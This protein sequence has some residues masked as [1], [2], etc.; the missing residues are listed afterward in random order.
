[1]KNLTR[2]LATIVAITFGMSYHAYA[3]SYTSAGAGPADWNTASSWTPAGI[4]TASDNVTISTGHTITIGAAGTCLGLTVNGTLNFTAN[5]VLSIHGNYIVNAGGTE[6]GTVGNL[7]FYTP[8]T[9][10]TTLGTISNA[11]RYYFYSSRTIAAGSVLTK[12]T[13][14]IIT[15][16]SLVITNKGN[17]TVS[18]I[19]AHSTST[20]VN[21]SGA[22]LTVKLNGFMSAGK[23]NASA[24]P[25]TVV[26]AYG[27]GTFSVPKTQLAS[28][29]YNLTI[30]TSTGT[31]SMSEDLIVAGNLTIGSSMTFNTNNFNLTVKG[32]W[33]NG[34][35]FV[36]SAGKTITL[37]GTTA[38]SVSNTTGTTTLKRLTINNT[39]GV[40]L[41]SGTYILDEVLTVSNG[42]F[43]TG[44]RPFTMTSTATQTARIAPITGTGA[45][46]GNFTIQRFITARDTTY[47]DFSSP[48]Q[49][50]T[51]NDWDN[52][53]PAISYS[54]SPPYQ[55]A[56]AST[57]DEMADA[58]VPVTSSGTSL[59]PGQGFEV[60]L[61]GDFSYSSLPATT[62][63]S[64]GVPNQGDFDLS[65]Q[66]SNT[67]QGWNLV[68]NPFASSISWSS[69]YTASGGA[70][71]G[72]YDYI[73][74]YDYTIADWNGYTSADGI[75][76]GATQGFWVYGLSGPM[77]LIIPE[78]SKTTTSNSSIKAPAR[79][80]PYFTL[81]MSSP[82]SNAAHIFKVAASVNGVDGLDN[83]DLPFRKSLNAATPEMYTLVDGKKIN[84]CSFNSSNDNYSIALRTKVSAA[85]KYRIDP[86]GY[87]FIPEYTCVKLL[88]KQS[89][90]VIDLNDGNGYCFMAS[91]TDN[92]DRFILM[93]SKDNNCK[94]AV[95]TAQTEDFGNEIEILPNANGN[96]V[97][98]NLAETTSSN[99]SVVNMLG[100]NITETISVNALDQ[101][102]NIALPED[103]AGMYIVRVESAKGAV[104]KKFVKK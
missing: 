89:G 15:G 9:T 88:D 8:G 36:A 85:G 103:F 94:S 75:E 46:A 58:Y 97:H 64:I 44:G 50:T 99:I 16:G 42:T 12:V 95:A 65:S 93:L 76:I 83:N 51:F 53:L 60:F 52:E 77:T 7:S 74:M 61:A 6:S 32:N 43:N 98:F 63:N 18:G 41:T 71:S 84:I 72:M 48:V 3:T 91:P 96:T 28:G 19:T 101:S 4:P 79:V 69:V 59:N 68:G 5:I 24:V 35:T 20:F 47:A 45:I 104:T 90:E 25:N 10:I 27:A 67:V 73:E 82:N 102:L 38:Q 14:P 22:T 2:I 92:P 34:S 49:S 78:S 21:G 37:S 13:T 100:Q 33:T 80:Q 23:F 55:Y 56:S 17:F 70:A 26:L 66:V 81:K 29:Y 11:T 86:A 30:N 31:K 40:T 54:Y 62:M 39:A 87:E 57:Y 1:M